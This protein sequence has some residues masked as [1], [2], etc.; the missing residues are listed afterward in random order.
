MLA[1]AR[2]LGIEVLVGHS[3]TD[4]A[5]RLRIRSMTVKR[6][7]STSGRKIEVDALIVSAGAAGWWWQ[8]RPVPDGPIILISIDTLR[9]DRLPAY[10]YTA[11]R[12]PAIDALAADGVLF[13]HAYTHSPQTLPAHTSIFSGRLPFAHGV[14]DNIGFTVKDDEAL[15]AQRLRD[16]GYATGAFVS[17][18]VLRSAVGLARGFDVYDDALQ[19]AAPSRPLGQVQRPGAQTVDAAIA[20]INRQATDRFFLFVHLYE[21]HTPYAPPPEFA[22]ANP[23]DGEVAYADALVGR[24]MAALIAAG[25][26]HNATIIFLSDHGE[27][28]G[29]HGEDEHGMFLYRETIQVPLIIRLPAGASAGRRVAEPVQH[30]DLVPTVLD[31]IGLPSGRSDRAALQGRSLLPVLRGA[32]ALPTASIYAETL[33]PRLHFGWSELYALTDDRYRYIR[34]PRDE[35]YDLSQDPGERTSI[36]ESRGPVRAAMRQALEALLAGAT[37]S[38]PSAVSESDR[39]RLAALGYV[40]TQRSASLSTPGDALPDPKD[41]LEGGG[42]GGGGG[43]RRWVP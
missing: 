8:S 16:R 42:G 13:E 29:D 33:S 30:I 9:A 1:E 22:S 34:A 28:L 37:V 15:L 6:N 12:T 41:K 24:L 3:V 20:W 21:P 38:A 10:G 23:Y 40:G 39:Q 26:H 43:G 19:K 25:H 27:G 5:G 7:G 4:T 35:L 17:S 18:Y 14:R 32:G 2:S 31:L 36:A 11:I